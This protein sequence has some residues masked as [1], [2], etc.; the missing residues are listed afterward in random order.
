VLLTKLRAA[1]RPGAVQ[2]VA[3]SA[4]MGGLDS[5]SAWLDA[6]LFMTN[7]RPVPL[8]E[9][10]VMGGRVYRKTAPLGEQGGW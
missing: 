6:R 9:H 1:A 4:T 8:T 3:M 5:L 2:V 7:F 10:V